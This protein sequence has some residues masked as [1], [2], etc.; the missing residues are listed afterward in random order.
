MV[1]LCTLGGFTAGRKV[2]FF[3]THF[4]K[5]KLAKS[6]DDFDAVFGKHVAKCC[7]TTNVIR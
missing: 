5:I 4:F 1:F 2:R 7:V 3:F 6:L